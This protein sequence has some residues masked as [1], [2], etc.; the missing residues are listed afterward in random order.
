MSVSKSSHNSAAF[1]AKQHS[2][3]SLVEYASKRRKVKR[4]RRKRQQRSRLIYILPRSDDD[5]LSSLDDT[6]FKS[7]GG[8]R[9]GVFN[10][11]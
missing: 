2:D 5:N 9:G 3:K 8:V 4:V 7:Q 11:S 10:Y 1:R 6:K